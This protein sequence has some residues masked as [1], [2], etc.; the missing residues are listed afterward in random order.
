MPYTSRTGKIAPDFIPLGKTQVLHGS[1][2]NCKLCKDCCDPCEACALNCRTHCCKG[3]DCCKDCKDCKC[4]T[5]ECMVQ[6]CEPCTLQCPCLPLQCPAC[7]T[8]MCGPCCQYCKLNCNDCKPSCGTL[9]WRAVGFEIT[10]GVGALEDLFGVWHVASAEYPACIPACAYPCCSVG[11]PGLSCIC[12]GGKDELKQGDNFSIGGPTVTK[13]V[14]IF[15]YCCSCLPDSLFSPYARIKESPLGVFIDPPF[16]GQPPWWAAPFFASAGAA[17]P[18]PA[19][20]GTSGFKMPGMMNRG[21]GATKSPQA[22]RP[23]GPPASGS[24]GFAKAAGK[25][26]KKTAKSQAAGPSGAPGG[27]QQMGTMPPGMPGKWR[28]RRSFRVCSLFGI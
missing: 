1:C 19:K 6:C 22:A 13:Q 23:S 28:V 21:A 25:T 18:R 11:L 16:D 24:L 14:S 5:A 9:D 26:S 17:A 12:I 7:C 3:G 27:P 8:A 4:C 2:R 20:S 15:D 10:L